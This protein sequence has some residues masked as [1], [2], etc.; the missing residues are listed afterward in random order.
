MRCKRCKYGK[1]EEL[2]C[3]EKVWFCYGHALVEP[4]KNYNNGIFCRKTYKKRPKGY[5]DEQLR[6]DFISG[7][8]E[9]SRLST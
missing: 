9:W 1:L 5:T 3:G 2:V 7:V 6:K 8:K 4:T